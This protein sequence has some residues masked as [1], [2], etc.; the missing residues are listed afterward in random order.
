MDRKFKESLEELVPSLL[1]ITKLKVKKVDD[2]VV[3]CGSFVGLFKV[4]ILKPK[5]I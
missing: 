4:G 2:R 5:A 1:S 3:T